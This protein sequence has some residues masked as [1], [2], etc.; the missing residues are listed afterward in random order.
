MTCSAQ[1]KVS[2]ISHY[3]KYHGRLFLHR[4][5]NQEGDVSNKT[6]ELLMKES[7]IASGIKNKKNK[8]TTKY[9]TD[10]EED[11]EFDELRKQNNLFAL[12]QK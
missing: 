3:N 9:D 12:A 1:M 2:G 7:Y 8:K 11:E 10:S 4:T 5:I 6:L